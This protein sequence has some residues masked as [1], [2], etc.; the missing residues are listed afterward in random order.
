MR[1]ILA[2][3]SFVLLAAACA[4]TTVK[5]PA[6]NTNK[7]A[8]PKPAAAV[9]ESGAE[10]REK[11]VW[12]AVQKKNYDTF[13]NL[14]A[15]DYIEVAGDAVYDKAGSLKAV[16]DVNLTDVTLSNWKLLP[17]DK[18]AFV[19]TYTANIKGTYQGQAFP[20]GPV[21][22]SSAW[23]NR[24]AKWVVIYHQETEAKTMPAPPAP[25]GSPTPR[26]AASPASKP[27]EPG[28]DPIANEKIVWDT[29]KSNNYDAFAALLA[30]E[31]VE[32]E[33]DNV[34]DK[35]SAVKGASEFDASKFELS[36]FKSVRLDSD[37]SLVTYLVKAK[38]P[39]ADQE[40]HSS[41]WI[42]RGA[43]WLAIFH[44]GTPA[45]KPAK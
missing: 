30:P 33:A 9:S 1:K 4:T 19:I 11:E 3:V 22:A 6:T 38:G 39:N 21:R 17:I 10:A 8:E 41:I 16:K 34:Y 2:L 25:K 31:F 44:Q 27:A 15:G 24:D 26:A 7:A 36:D 32:V 13:G 12:D 5:E 18:D 28:P 42:N 23:V 43:K 37:A 40:R 35:A 14:L 29:F 45:P 20:T